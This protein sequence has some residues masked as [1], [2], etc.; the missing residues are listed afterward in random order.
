MCLH[1]PLEDEEDEEDSLISVVALPPQPPPPPAPH[2]VERHLCL[3]YNLFFIMFV[4]FIFQV[5]VSGH[6]GAYINPHTDV[7]TVTSHVVHYPQ[8]CHGFWPFPFS[9]AALAG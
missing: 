7:T 3:K 1:C 9:P 8:S 6:R 4:G 2:L 5:C